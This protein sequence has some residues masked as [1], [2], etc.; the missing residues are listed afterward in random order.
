MQ[1]SLS[2]VV[3]ILVSASHASLSPYT[4]D[5]SYVYATFSNADKTRTIQQCINY[6]QWQRMRVP[7]NV[8]R[9]LCVYKTPYH[10]NPG[11]ISCALLGRR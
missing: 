6:Q 11:G 8:S 10:L 4:Y 9:N 3:I 1:T 5:S 7:D 2:L